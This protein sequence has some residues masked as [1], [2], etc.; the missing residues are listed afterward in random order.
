MNAK[1][2]DNLNGW[3]GLAFVALLVIASTANATK[4]HDQHQ[5]QTQDTHVNTEQAQDTVVDVDVGSTVS[6]ANNEGNS[7]SLESTYESGPA[8][9]VLVPNNNT[10][11]CLRVF[12]F[13]GGNREGSAMFGVPFRSHACDFD[14]AADAAAAVGDHETA[15]FWRCHK[16]ALWKTYAIGERKG[17]KQRAVAACT[18]D[19]AGEAAKNARLLEQDRRIQRLIDEREHDRR[20]CAESKQRIAD[21]WKDSTCGQAK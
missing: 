18:A 1:T 11:S 7:L 21:A 5:D 16:K 6:G 15:W 4:T 2:R 3:L 13:S 10:E 9:L 19:M 20:E 12:G 14:K 8:D 17:R